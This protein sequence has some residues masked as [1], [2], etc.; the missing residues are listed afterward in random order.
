MKKAK[1]WWYYYKWYVILGAI[2]LGII[3][4]I[5]GNALELWKKAPDFQIAYVG[6][7]PLPEDTVNALEQA[8]A[9][10]GSDFN[11]DG[12]VIV[13]VNQYIDSGSKVSSDLTYEYGS[14]ITLIADITNCDSYFFI[15]EDP[16]DFQRSWQ[17]LAMSDGSCPGDTDYSAEG[18]VFQWS[19]SPV[20][21]QLPLGTYSSNTLGIE[22]SGNSQDLLSGLYVGRRCFYTDTQTPNIDQCSQLWASI[23]PNSF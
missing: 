13:H 16:E 7:A 22:N 2:L 8:F 4:Y 5:A 18:K 17:I 19:Q 10:L 11:G 3:I 1:N 23:I 9:E 6:S 14:E 12:S 21:S 15:V 20:L